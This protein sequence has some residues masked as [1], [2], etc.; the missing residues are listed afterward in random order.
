M[1]EERYIRLVDALVVAAGRACPITG[2]VDRTA[3]QLA[4]GEAGGIWPD[5]L[6]VDVV[7]AHVDHL[8]REDA[9]A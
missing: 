2:G 7:R 9:A 8:R 4:L 6:L 3:L 5:G 1:L